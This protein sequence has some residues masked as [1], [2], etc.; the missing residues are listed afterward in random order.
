MPFID[1]VRKKE[2]MRPDPG[3]AAP[4]D[5]HAIEVIVRDACSPYIARI[6]LQPG[7][8]LGDYETLIGE[9]QAWYRETRQAE[10]K[11]LKRVFVV[12]RLA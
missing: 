8:M 6:G 11:G 7:P 10:E 5:R 2:E 1:Y 3:R 9:G 12:R 4:A